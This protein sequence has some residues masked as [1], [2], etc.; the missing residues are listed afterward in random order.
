MTTLQ[1][2][3]VDCF[4]DRHGHQRFYFRRGHGPR[5][6]LPG[7]PGEA[8]FM[9]AYQAALGSEKLAAKLA[10]KKLRGDPGTFDRLVTEYFVSQEFLRL[11]HRPSGP[12]AMSSSALFSTKRSAIGWS[13]RCA[14]SMSI[15]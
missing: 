6:A 8:N 3:H 13:P 14:A 9:A 11:S 15:A 1:L 2:K 7:L 12:T 4:T 5:M 10:T